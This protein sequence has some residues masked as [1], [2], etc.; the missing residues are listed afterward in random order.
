PV[1]PKG[2]HNAVIQNNALMGG[3]DLE[4]A[5]DSISVIGNVI[6][7]NMVVAHPHTA[8]E[9]KQMPG[10][11]NVYIAHNNETMPGGAVRVTAG[12]HISILYNQFEQPYRN[13]NPDDAVIAVHGSEDRPVDSVLI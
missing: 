8:I 9:V 1:H 4:N 6:F 7:P 5:G 2:L 3:I 12:E 13:T 11:S 10:A